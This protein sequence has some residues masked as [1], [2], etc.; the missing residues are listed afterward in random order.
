MV[1]KR[2]KYLLG[3][4]FSFQMD[5]NSKNEAILTELS[6]GFE[7]KE[8]IG[9]DINKVFKE[10]LDKKG[11]LVEPVSIINDTTATFLT[12]SFYE[13]NVDISVIVGTG[14][15]ICFKDK[16]GELI[17]IESGYFSQNLPLSYYDLKHLEE[18]PKLKNNLM[19][20][21]TG[22]KY[23]GETANYIIKDLKEQGLLKIKEEI[24]GKIL[25]DSLTDNLDERFNE[26]EKLAI[27]YIAKILLRRSTKLI[28]A[29]IVAI[30]NEIDPDLSKNHTII[31]D[32][33]VYEKNEYFRNNLDIYFEKYYQKKSKKIKKI[34]IKNASSIGAVLSIFSFN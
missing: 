33:S 19:E 1:D 30:L 23:I 17:N 11:I 26:E 6:K 2:R 7:L 24:D 5:S 27:S 32:G 3:H 34:F 21:I 16:Y 31:F 15:N 12:G 28:V 20:L 25:T 14:H 18:E 13:R 10:A 29:E 8:A 9:K 22:G 4:T